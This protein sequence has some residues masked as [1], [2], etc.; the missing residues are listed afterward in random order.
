MDTIQQTDR[1]AQREIIR[2]N[3][4]EIANDIGTM[5]RDA[6][7]LFPVYITVRDSG[8]SLATVATPLDPSDNDW[9][10]A[11]D[12]VCRIMEKKIGSGGLWSRELLCAVANSPPMGAAEVT[13]SQPLNPAH[14]RGV[15]QRTSAARE[16][17]VRP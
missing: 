7:L 12:I 17:R 13:T 8:E 2:S 14:A 11:S 6:G 5:M 1:D 15:A 3:L 16:N 9:R 10:R 4:T